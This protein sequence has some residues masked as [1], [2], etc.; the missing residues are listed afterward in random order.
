MPSRS[1]IISAR[2]L[3]LR[4]KPWEGP[5]L[6]RAA[7]H[8]DLLDCNGEVPVDGLQ[9]G[10]VAD[11]R[12]LIS[13]GAPLD[14]NLAVEQVHGSQDGP[15]QGGLAGPARSEQ[16][17]EVAAIDGETHVFQDSRAVVSARNAHHLD[18]GLFALVLVRGRVKH[19]SGYLAP[20]S[21]SNTGLGSNPDMASTLPPRAWTM[22]LTFDSMSPM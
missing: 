10:D 14:V 3:S 4:R 21:P 2:S 16:P 22:L 20:L 11:S 17:D 13:D 18:D 7:H 12:P 5:I 9:L 15:Q 19:Y 6:G 1:M 8:H